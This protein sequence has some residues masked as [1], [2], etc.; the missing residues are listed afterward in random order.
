MRK[1]TPAAVILVLALA[2]LALPVRG[3]DTA[4]TLK[5]GFFLPSDSVFRDVYASPPL[6]G[7]DLTVPLSG[8]LQFWAGAEYIGK[9]GLLPV[10]EEETKVRLIPLYAGLR[11]QFGR[12]NARP[13]I[14]AAAAYFMLHE[15]NP[16][17][18]ASESGLGLL[19]QAGVQLRLVGPVWLDLFAGYRLGTVKTDDEDPLEADLGGLSVGLGA[20]FKF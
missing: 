10:S 18:S 15:E 16:I 14:G 3:A 1:A 4:V 6:F 20:S 2:G 11:A 7:V 13:Y 17:G 5:A 9:T 19:T 12:K 8:P